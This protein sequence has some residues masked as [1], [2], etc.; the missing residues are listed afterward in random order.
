MFRKSALPSIDSC[1]FESYSL[2]CSA[3]GA[4][5]AGIVDPSDDAL[6]LTELTP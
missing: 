4:E 5:L 2:A 6:L 3:C 1:G